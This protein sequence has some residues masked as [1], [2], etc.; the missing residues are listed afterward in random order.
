MTATDDSAAPSP[1]PS[2]VERY[3]R[4]HDH[5][6]S[7]DGPRS[8]ADR[9]C[10][11]PTDPSGSIRWH[12]TAAT[13]MSTSAVTA[14]T[15]ANGG[16]GEGFAP[17]RRGRKALRG[18]GEVEATITAGRRFHVRGVSA[19][20]GHRR[21]TFPGVDG[22]H[23]HDARRLRRH[24]LRLQRS[25][26]DG[27]FWM[28]NTPMPLSI[29]YFDASRDDGLRSRHG[30]VRGLPVLSELPGR[31]PLRLRASKFRRGR[32]ADVGV[33]GRANIHIDANECPLAKDLKRP[34]A[35]GGSSPAIQ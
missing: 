28:R 34:P 32:L 21:T 35:L 14:P 23:R 26:V 25:R 20:R 10:R 6:L 9:L 31:R 17:A 33:S 22:G 1:S 19:G 27:A 12:P 5:R 30:P 2:L 15:L 7:G 13:A 24:G 16:I 4:S 8:G 3:E 18:F 11:R 29:A